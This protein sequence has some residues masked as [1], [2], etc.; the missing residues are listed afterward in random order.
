MQAGQ[1]VGA[2]MADLFED[3]HLGP[4]VGRDVRASPA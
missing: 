3:Y 2:G 4:G 1:R